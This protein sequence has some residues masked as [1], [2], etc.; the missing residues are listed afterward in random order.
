MDMH[1]LD[2][3]TRTP[4][5]KLSRT[6]DLAELENQIQRRWPSLPD[7]IML[8]WRDSP[9]A[10]I[11][12]SG[13]PWIFAPVERDPLRGSRGKTVIPRQQLARLKQIADLEVPFQRLAIAH[14]LDPQGPV[15][16][17]LPDLRSGPRTCTDE[18]ARTLVGD[19]PAH[20]GVV[21]AVR[22]LDAAVGGATSALPKQLLSALMDPIIFGIIAP[23]APRHGERCLWYPLVAWR[24]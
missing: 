1:T 4:F 17:L 24:W 10:A 18:L 13:T 22:A 23:T 19:L 15:H 20:P 16:H 12:R 5:Q 14:E 9:T 7:P 21:R 2:V 11:D 8:E 6:T 3:R